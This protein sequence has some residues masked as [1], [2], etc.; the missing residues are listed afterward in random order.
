M[1]AFAAFGGELL[2]RGF[3]ARAWPVFLA[4]LLLSLADLALNG[5]PS[6]LPPASTPSPPLPAARLYGNLVIL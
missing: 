2:G 1:L 3:P 6:P 5:L 4:L